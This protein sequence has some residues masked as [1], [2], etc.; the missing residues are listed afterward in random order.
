MPDD[1]TRKGPEDSKRINIHEDHE[2]RY[3]TSRFKIT[4]D[5]LRQAVDAVGPMV[6]DVERWLKTH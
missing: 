3:W 5:K 6:I 1:L 4:A 2:V